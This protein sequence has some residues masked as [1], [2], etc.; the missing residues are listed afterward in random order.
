MER[1]LILVTEELSQMMRCDVE[2]GWSRPGTP[3]SVIMW[4]A[5]M[6][7]PPVAIR[8]SRRYTTSTVGLEGSFE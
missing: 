2:E 5:A 1:S 4:S 3:Q 7:V 6:A 8:G